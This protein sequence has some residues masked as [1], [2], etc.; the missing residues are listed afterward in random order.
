[1]N[2]SP[3]GPNLK[4]LRRTKSVWTDYREKRIMFRPPVLKKKEFKE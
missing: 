2:K 4:N 1:M 3:E